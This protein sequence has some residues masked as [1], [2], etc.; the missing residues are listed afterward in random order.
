MGSLLRVRSQRHDWKHPVFSPVNQ[1][2]FLSKHKFTNVTNDLHNSPVLAMLAIEVDYCRILSKEHRSDFT[3]FTKEFFLLFTLVLTNATSFR[4]MMYMHPIALR[5]FN[6]L[7][8]RHLNA[9]LAP[10]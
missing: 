2:Q 6:A 4:L 3:F 9:S 5:H 1:K 7:S 8:A 10:H